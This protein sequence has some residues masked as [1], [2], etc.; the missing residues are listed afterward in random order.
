MDLDPNDLIEA[1]RTARR[2]GNERAARGARLN[3][4]VA[5]ATQPELASVGAPAAAAAGDDAAITK[6]RARR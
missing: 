6:Y 1:A 2:S 3:A 4:A 5:T